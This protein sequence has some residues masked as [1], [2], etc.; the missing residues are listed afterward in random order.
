MR[1]HNYCNFCFASGL[2]RL[3]ALF[4]IIVIIAEY[5]DYCYY[6]HFFNHTPCKEM[7]AY[8]YDITLLQ[9]YT[10]Y[11]IA[12][13][14]YDEG[15]RCNI[16]VYRFARSEQLTVC[17]F[18]PSEFHACFAGSCDGGDRWYCSHA[19]KSTCRCNDGT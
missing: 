4:A 3:F 10:S 14:R 18:L 2:Y 15:Y 19:E 5:L 17:W 6:L 1:Q 13:P 11:H 16:L 7:I 8:T 12:S 9:R